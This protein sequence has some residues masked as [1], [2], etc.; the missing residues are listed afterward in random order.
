MQF[1]HWDESI[2]EDEEQKKRFERAKKSDVK[3]LSIDHE[4]QTCFIQ[5][6]EN[7]PYFVTLDSCTCMDFS[8]RNL[9]CKHIYRLGME[10]GLIPGEYMSGISS[11]ELKDILPKLPAESQKALYEMCLCDRSIFLFPKDDKYSPLVENGFCIESVDDFV[12]A[13]QATACADLRELIAE[14]GLNDLPGERVQFKTLIA[15]IKKAQEERLAKVQSAFTAIELTPEAQE[16]RNT[17]SLM[18]QAREE[19]ILY[20]SQE[21][22]K[23]PKSLKLWQVLLLIF[24]WPVGLLYLILRIVKRNQKKESASIVSISK[25]KG[26]YIDVSNYF[27]KETVFAFQNSSVYH[28]DYY[29]CQSGWNGA[30]AMPEKKAIAKGMR[31]CRRCTDYTCCK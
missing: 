26:T 29:C 20:G 15:W 8:K 11:R 5:G 6:R 28:T 24:F 22:Q 17:I 13:A 7:E 27:P 2:H 30:E 9:P 18:L 12:P 19:Q 23:Q 14:S 25:P 1:C 4:N 31:L 16:L 3:P 21:P 10:L